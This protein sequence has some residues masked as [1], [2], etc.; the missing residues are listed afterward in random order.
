MTLASLPKEQKQYLVLGL[1]VAVALVVLSVFGIKISLA[2]IAEAREELK[3]VSDKIEAADRALAKSQDISAQ[4]VATATELKELLKNVPPTRNYYS[5][6][7]EIIYNLGRS[8]A[9]EIDAIDELSFARIEKDKKDSKDADGVRL[10][11]YTLRITA[12]GGYRNVKE[13]LALMDEAHPMARIIGMEISSSGNRPEIHDIELLI[14]WPFNTDAIAKIWESV[15]ARQ[16]VVETLPQSTRVVVDAEPKPVEAPAPVSAV[17]EKI[18]EVET[19]SVPEKVVREEP[20]TETKKPVTLP[21][22]GLIQSMKGSGPEKSAPPVDPSTGS[23]EN[24]NSA[25]K[26][27]RILQSGTQKNQKTL[28]SVLESLTEGTHENP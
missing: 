5:W 26:L 18:P 24:G 16:L 6:A 9:L 23:I 20:V 10:E 17:S 7:T 25:N 13:F 27:E 28:G 8:A 14:Q 11:T 3:E 1:L 21:L 15:T 12:H 2:S 22:E 19:S 4:Y